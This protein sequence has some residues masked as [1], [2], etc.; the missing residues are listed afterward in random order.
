MPQWQSITG[1]K[2]GP[3]QQLLLG[4]ISGPVVLHPYTEKY[5]L[6]LFIGEL[7][8]WEQGRRLRN[9]VNQVS[10]YSLSLGA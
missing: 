10:F 1:R 9:N 4:R 7:Y 5:P 6:P 3:S 8:I 2:H